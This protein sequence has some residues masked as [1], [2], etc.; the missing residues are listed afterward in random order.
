MPASVKLGEILLKGLR[1]IFI[2]K[3]EVCYS[4]LLSAPRQSKAANIQ[5]PDRP[6]LQKE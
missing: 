3:K 4:K 5:Q 1:P 2:K 6:G